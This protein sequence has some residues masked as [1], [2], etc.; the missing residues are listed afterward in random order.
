MLRASWRGNLGF[1]FILVWLVA[2]ATSLD[3][4]L[5]GGSAAGKAMKNP[6]AASSESIAAGFEGGWGSPIVA[7]G[8]VYLFT[9]ARKQQSDSQLPPRKFPYLPDDKRGHLTPKEYEEYMR[10]YPEG[11]DAEAVQQRLAA[12]VTLDGATRPTKGS[13][14]GSRWQIDAAV[15]QEEH[16]I[17]VGPGRE[18]A[19]LGHAEDP[20]RVR[21]HDLHETVQRDA[22]LRDAVYWYSTWSWNH[23]IDISTL[24]VRDVG[25]VPD[26]DVRQRRL[27][28]P[29][30]GDVRLRR[31]HQ[32][33][34]RGGRRAGAEAGRCSLHSAGRS[35]WI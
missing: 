21:A 12:I 11:A 16:E 7:G 14:D 32:L 9:H 27:H 19:L 10:R 22:A 2:S 24:S 3:A 29:G 4:Q 28:P 23:G 25:D 31:P 18:V 33:E 13:L 6:V 1:I 15:A 17:G 5:P 30:A 8:K 34:H 20:R 26:P 35:A